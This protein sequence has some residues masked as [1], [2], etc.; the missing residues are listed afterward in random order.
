[1]SFV[2]VLPVGGFVGWRFLERTLERQ[3][4]SFARSPAGLR[5]EDYFRANIG[6]VT[7]AADLVSDR[8]L[9]R[10]ALSA[11]GLSDDLPN[12]AFIEKVLASDTTERGSFVNRLA[13][14]RYA[15]LSQAFGFGNILGPQTARP[16]VVEGIIQRS[17]ELRFEQALGEQ[18]PQM[19]LALSLQRDLRRLAEQS[20]TEET[21]WFTVLGTPSLR[22]VFETAYTLPR[23]FAGIDIERQVEILRARTERLTGDPGIGQFSVPERMDQLIRRFF[24]G[25]QLSEIQTLAPGS[26][27]LTLLQ[28]MPSIRQLARRA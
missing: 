23:E 3:E 7:S 17:R 11:Y 26:A 25:A 6:K 14:K 27:A 12:R 10:V 2:P 4:A 15:E 28:S 1:M 13:D 24:V 21:K 20:S 8:K 9:L 22:A 5:D 19:R 18:D 16:S